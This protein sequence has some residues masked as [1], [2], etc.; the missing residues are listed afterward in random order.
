M[1]WVTGNVTNDGSVAF[2]PTMA[3]VLDWGVSAY[4]AAGKILPASSQASTKSGA[5]DRFISYVWLTGDL[6]ELVKDFPTAQQNWTGALLLPRELNVRVIPNVVD[7]EL[8]REPLT[9]WRVAREGSGQI[10]LETMGISIARET[11]SALTSGPSFIESGKTLSNAESV[12]FNTSPSSKFFVLTA[13]ISFP[14]SARDS[15]I[16]AGFQVLSSSLESTTIYYQFS[17]ESIIIDRSNTS[18]AARTTAGI[19]SDNE[20]GRLRLFDV[21]RNGEEQIETLELTIVVDNSVLEVYA[22]GRFAL[23][24]WAR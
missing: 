14:T 23:G 4:A 12:P 9:S 11:Y 6:F 10:D 8:A 17:N 15:G 5:P 16:Q 20:V 24:T 19:L 7:N 13:N 22:N 2:K 3:G 21:L 1:L 18:A